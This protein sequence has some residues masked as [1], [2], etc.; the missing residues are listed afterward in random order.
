MQSNAKSRFETTSVSNEFPNY[1]SILLLNCSLLQ[2][3]FLS[4]ESVLFLAPDCEVPLQSF[5]PRPVHHTYCI[6][7]TYSTLM[8]LLRLIRSSAGACRQ[9]RH[10]QPDCSH[11]KIAPMR[12]SQ[13]SWIFWSS[14]SCKGIWPGRWRHTEPISL[15]TTNLMQQVTRMRNKPFSHTN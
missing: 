11:V 14:K 13:L 15:P 10:H 7:H 3:T 6:D 2:N 4:L 8:L 9:N 5:P 1:L 12:S